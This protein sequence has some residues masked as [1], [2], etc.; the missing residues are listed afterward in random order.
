MVHYLARCRLNYWAS[1]GDHQTTP[2]NEDVEDALREFRMCYNQDYIG[3][4]PD[5]CLAKLKACPER[6]LFNII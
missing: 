6:H 5:G 1:G 3:G 4:I 2:P